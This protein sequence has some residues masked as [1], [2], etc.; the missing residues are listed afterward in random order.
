MTQYDKY[1]TT[2]SSFTFGDDDEQDRRDETDEQRVE[3]AE[4]YRNQ[5]QKHLKDL[6]DLLEHVAGQWVAT[7]EQY[8]PAGYGY[9]IKA[10][11][12]GGA[13]IHI[14]PLYDH[15]LKCKKEVPLLAS[16]ASTEMP[17]VAPLLAANAM[18][19]ERLGHSGD[20]FPLAA[21]QRDA[22]SHYL[23][24]QQG[25][26]LA[27]NGPPGTGKTTLVLSIIATEWARAA[28]NKTE[29]PVVIATSTNNQA[30]TNIIEAFGK[31][32]STGTG[33]MAGRW[34]PELKSYGAYLPS[35]GRK[36]DAAKKYQTDDFFYRVESLEYVEDA[37][38]FY[39]E[40]VR[41]A[42]PS[43]DCS[44]PERVVDLLHACLTK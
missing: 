27:V 16:F 19:S 1:K 42:F 14:R 11:Q 24:Q 38:V 32:F 43:A 7:Y 10:N 2:H 18:L 25:E 28:L 21:A 44:S 31:D 8:E 34:L 29:P 6:N 3:R 12:P 5:W 36:A 40:K 30:V 39:L 20:E 26:I 41:A 15:L 13:S 22:L 4:K 37:L 17:P 9:V 33:A 23:T 35:S